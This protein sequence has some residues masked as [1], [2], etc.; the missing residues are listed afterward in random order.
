MLSKDTALITMRQC[1]P[2]WTNIKKRTSKSI[3]GALLTAYAHESDKIWEAILDYQKIFFLVNYEGHEDEFPDYLYMAM[4][5]THDD[6]TVTSF[7]CDITTYEDEFLNNLDTKVLYEGGYLLFHE[8]ILPKDV[9]NSLIITYS[10]DDDTYEYEIEITRE[11]IWNAF[12]EFA[13]FAGLKRYANETNKELAARTYAVF[14]N[15]PNPTDTGL[16][17]AIENA[18]IPHHSLTDEEIDI[19]PIGSKKFDMTKKDYQDIYEAFVQFNH[20][21][22]RT[23]IWNKDFWSH[24]FQKTD[25]IPHI[26]DAPMEAI[27]PGVGYNDS[28]RTDYLKRLSED[29]TTD[30]TV[31]SYQKDF[32]K[33]RQYIGRTNIEASITLTLTKYSDAIKPKDIEYRIDA[34][35][36]YLIDSPQSIHICGTKKTSGTANY[37]LDGLVQDLYDVKRIERGTLNPNTH[38]LLRFTPKDYFAGMDVNQCDLVTNGKPTDIRKAYSFY[39]IK[40]NVLTNT[41]V[42]AHITNTAQLATNQNLEDAVKGITVGHQ[43]TKGMMQIDVTGMERQLVTTKV[44]C[45]E[46]DITSSSYVTAKNGFVLQGQTTY[47]AS[48]T[49]SLSELDI[50]GAGHELYCNSYSFTFGKSADSTRQGAIVV[51]TIVNGEISTVTYRDGTTITNSFQK[52]TQVEIIIQKYGQNPVTISNIKMASYDIDIHMSDN[53]PLSQYG[54]NLRLPTDISHK[55]LQIDITPYTAAFPIIEYVHIG[56]SLRGARY[57][58]DF[59]T[60]AGQNKL[61]IDTDCNVTLYKIVDDQNVLVGK[62]NEF[63]TKD[64]FRNDTDHTGYLTL[65]LSDFSTIQSAVPE[66]RKWFSGTNKSYIRVE[67]GVSIDTIEIAGESKRTITNRTLA[68]YLLG[69]DIQNKKIYASRG[70]D[71]YIL[72][73][74]TAKHTVERKNIPYSALDSRAD[75]FEI[76]GLPAD[77]SAEFLTSDGQSKEYTDASIGTIFD[78]ISLTYKGAK[79]YVAYNSV[80][81]ITE[82]KEN[83]EIVNTFTPVMQMSQLRY[84]V[85]RQAKKTDSNV[86]FGTSKSSWSFGVDPK[87]IT[88]ET[89]L[90]TEN[91]SSWVI[92]ID[93]VSNRY[94]L[95]NEIPLSE[96]YYIETDGLYHDTREFMITPESGLV[97]NYESENGMEDHFVVNSARVNKLRFSNTDDVVL[98]QG[99][100]RLTSGFTIMKDEGLILWTD[101]SKIGTSIRAVYT[102]R[103][104]VSVSYTK[105]YEDKLYQLISFTTEAYKLSESKTYQDC[106]DG[107]SINLSFSKPYDRIVTRCSNTAFTASILNGILTAVKVRD[108][109]Y[110]AVHNGYIYDEEKEYFYLN[111]RFVDPVDYTKFVEFHDTSRQNGN[112][113]LHMRSTNFLP[114]SNMRGTNLVDLCSIDFTKRIP[115]TVSTFRHLTACESY[116]LWYTVDMKLSIVENV[117]NGYGISFVARNNK[118]AYA[119]LPVTPYL[120]KDYAVS[121]YITGDLAAYLVPEKEMDEIPMTKSIYLD[122]KDGIPFQKFEDYVYLMT[123][124]D[125]KPETRYYLLIAGTKGTIDDLVSLPYTTKAAIKKSHTKNIDTLN[126]KID[127][128]LPKQYVYDLEFDPQGASYQD[129]NCNSQTQ[130]LTTSADIEYGLTLIHSV[131]LKN[132]QLNGAQEQKNVITFVQDNDAYINTPLIYLHSKSSAYKA[133]FKINDVLADRYKDFTIEVYGSNI[134]N[135]SYQLLKRAENTNDICLDHSEIRSYL[136]AKIIAENQKVIYSID[137]YARYAEIEG[138]VLSSSPLS[139]GTFISKIYDLGTSAKYRFIGAD[140]TTNG[141]DNDVVFYVRGMREGKLSLVF[142]PWKQFDPKA[143]ELNQIEYED[144]SLFQFKVEIKSSAVV[145]KLNAFRM[146]VV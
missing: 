26:W 119:A 41:N 62:E 42:K 68:Y 82:K 77:L 137:V 20:D 57:E 105:E 21:L 16:K 32:E 66:I 56:G 128:K 72:V 90:E 136:Y 46:I 124:K 89:K 6:I 122:P 71:G 52:R 11:Q 104:P 64:L 108:N 129:L 60:P 84:Y 140:Y 141:H 10:V 111:D 134:R 40:N 36:T 81:M 63:V 112:V 87:G 79:Q 145:L 37:Y 30:I 139:K 67:P 132:C 91:E 102:V 123:D 14:K 107:Q 50:G 9:L 33:I 70:T 93:N 58:L 31:N 38:Y 106:K 7:N 22:F 80:S 49:D 142:T 53:T 144:Y 5:G 95:A 96:K 131:N 48:G 94:I 76:T 135:G 27:Q 69:S 100:T 74:N 73:Q 44:S 103:H 65:D 8:K 29:E 18:V 55:L 19:F 12:D 78:R 121:L 120:K 2:S 143:S 146:E 59:T 34:Y 92:T 117:R 86:Y 113:L 83:I 138:A 118:I 47:T 88:V 24:P 13:L 130:E 25:Y 75:H 98:Y 4:V 1:F 110:I 114:H 127:E 3:G 115:E 85:L 116:N 97:V 17:H 28:L 133:Y 125:L 99:N 126:F 101:S 43:D 51:T 45:R 15:W 35:D 54:N 23:K 109:N 61:D 39:Q